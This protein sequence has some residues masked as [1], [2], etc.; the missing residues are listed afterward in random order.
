MTAEGLPGWGPETRLRAGSLRPDDMLVEVTPWKGFSGVRLVR[1]LD[2]VVPEPDEERILLSF[3]DGSFAV[4][5]KR[6][7]VARRR[8]RPGLAR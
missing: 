2:S 3:A 5:S 4:P 7:V 8:A 6:I 1:V